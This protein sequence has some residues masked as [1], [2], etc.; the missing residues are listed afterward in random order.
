MVFNIYPVIDN[1]MIVFFVDQN[2]NLYFYCSKLCVIY[3]VEG[4]GSY[5]VSETQEGESM[6]GILTLS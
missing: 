4:G 3:Y 2:Q 5:K 6:C 1:N